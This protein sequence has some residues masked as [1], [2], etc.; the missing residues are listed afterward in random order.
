MISTK[1]CKIG[2]E[3]AE[4]NEVGHPFLK[5]DQTFVIM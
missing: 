1:T 2:G 3:M 5:M 4:K